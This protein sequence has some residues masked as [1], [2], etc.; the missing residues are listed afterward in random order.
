MSN[1]STVSEFILL[2]FS[3]IRELQILYFATFFIIYLTALI[4]NLLVIIVVALNQSL[5]TPMYFFLMNL[6]TVDLGY[7]SV[8]IPKVMNNSLWATRQISYVACVTQLFFFLVFLSSEFFLLTVM[9]YDR[10]VAICNPLQY[11]QLMNKVSCVQ[12]TAAVWIISF[13]NAVLHTTC[14]FGITF[15]SNVINQFF[16]EIPQILRLSCSSSFVPEKGA[17]IACSL[18]GV[19]CFAFIVISYLQIFRA[20]LKIPSAQGRKKAISTCLPH[21]IVLF[22][23]YF[24]GSVAYLRPM[25]SSS[26]D[27][28]LAVAVMYSIIP[29]FMNPII[30]SIR[31]KEIM[32]GL[33]RLLY[34]NKI[35][36]F[37]YKWGV[38][39]I[40]K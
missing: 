17:V 6:S 36:T 8:T 13:C 3:D 10:F 15:C 39:F 21:L 20:V 25:S 40:K 26:S 19:G 35:F 18:L 32:S 5:H 4:G 33:W 22:L 24:T 12:M 16:C 27:T 14:T 1:Q 11:E 30:Y 7:I 9:A 28:N 2:G 37:T 34:K 29:P 23:F 38:G 31:N